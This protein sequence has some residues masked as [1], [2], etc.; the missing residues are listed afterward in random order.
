VA[1]DPKALEQLSRDELIS[2]ARSLGATRPEL[3]TR[4]ELR[5]EIIRLTVDDEATRRRARG[6]FGVARDLVASVVS[7]GLNLPDTVELIRGVGIKSPNAGPPVATVTLAEIYAAQGHVAKALVLL[8]E[9]LERE[10]D[11]DAAR[12]AR[13]RFVPAVSKVT[14]VMP[15]EPDIETDAITHEP[16]STESESTESV[17]NAGDEPATA[18]SVIH[19]FR[20]ESEL[21]P[22]AAG[23]GVEGAGVEGAGVAEESSATPGSYGDAPPAVEF[24]AGVTE[25]SEQ[26]AQER[27]APIPLAGTSEPSEGDPSVGP[28]L[29]DLGATPVDRAPTG[30]VQ[31][32]RHDVTIATLAASE[33]DEDLFLFVWTGP[34]RAMV[35]WQLGRR[36]QRRLGSRT[37]AVIGLKLLEVHSSWDG[38][39]CRESIVEVGATEGH[40]SIDVTSREVR[41][42][43]GWIESGS[44]RTLGIAAEFDAADGIPMVLRWS[45]PF[46]RTETQWRRLARE[47]LAAIGSSVAE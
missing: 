29:P 16:E 26:V 9:V 5:D 45:P 23:A 17:F 33:L 28:S 21:E 32:E 3:L 40:R 18:V 10:P 13:E 38:P 31:E 12:A 20:R 1:I 46:G 35:S 22:P 7:Q 8:D 25:N 34:N 24:V 42:A 4:P 15:P 19:G 39:V 14:P 11:H 37:S 41:V 47:R 27:E 2:R 36:S 43:M 6:W 30:G 44:F